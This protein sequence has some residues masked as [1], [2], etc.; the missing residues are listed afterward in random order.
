MI[1]AEMTDFNEACRY[2]E[3]AARLGS[4][5]GLDRIR[6]LCDLL[7]NPEDKL[8]FIHIAGTNGKGSTAA[9]IASALKCAGVRVGMY[10]SPA[11]S[12]IKDHYMIDGQLI[13]DEDY[14][15][16]ISRVADANEKLIEGTGESA[17]QFEL[18]TA[19]AFSYFA[20]N[21]CDVVVCECG[22]GGLEDATNV[23][24]NKLC[25]VIASVSFDHMQYLGNTLTE[26]ARAKAGIIIE[27]CPAVALDSNEEVIEEIRKRC[28]ITG[29]RLYI[30]EPDEIIY[31]PD[32][33]GCIN[34]S[35]NDLRDVK[36]GLA[37]SY[38]A[39]NAA[40]ALQTLSVISDSGC[41]GHGVPDEKAIRSG[42]A[43]VSWPFRFEKISSE[44][45]IYVDGAHNAD[46]AVKLLRTIKERLEGFDIILVMAMFADKEVEKVVNTLAPYAKKVIV[47]QTKDNI[48]ALDADELSVI[49]RKYCGH[50]TVR[51]DIK[52]A[53]ALAE[54]ECKKHERAAVVACGSLSYLNDF[55]NGKSR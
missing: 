18:E 8:R 39:E 42:L 26:I 31:S 51:K 6:M 4:R 32:D 17:T 25:C 15:K 12:G 34:V 53:Y 40:L 2:I 41:F 22:M 50:V 5:P 10:Y 23:I 54:E 38:Q 29:S 47:T 28:S 21:H 11:L 44:P 3:D 37:G 35:Y 55:K 27:G 13:S 46:A 9:M 16:A 49:V 20:E 7:G 33:D 52:E 1:S 30:V 36:V 43:N 19:V 45:L 48:R 24:K 14:T